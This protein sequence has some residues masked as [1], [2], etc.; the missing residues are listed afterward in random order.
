MK[1]YS[2]LDPNKLLH[3]IIRKQDALGRT[4]ISEPHQF[5]QLATLRMDKGKTFRP[6][7]HIWVDRGVKEMIAQ[8]SWCVIQGAVKVTFFDTDGSELCSEYI[9]QGDASITYEGGHTYEIQEDDTI[10]YEYKTGPYQGIEKD[11]VFI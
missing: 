2:N 11:K 10:V 5:I 8:E 4:D 6:H 3:M 1:I 9:Y 7:Q